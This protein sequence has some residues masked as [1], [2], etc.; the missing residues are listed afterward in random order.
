[1]NAVRKV[2]GV[3][4]VAFIGIPVLFGIIWAVG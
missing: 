4:V 3:F 2:L 1:M